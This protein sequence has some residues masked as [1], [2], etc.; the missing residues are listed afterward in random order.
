M[1]VAGIE[2]HREDE[3]RGAD[4]AHARLAEAL[5]LG[6]IRRFG[7]FEDLARELFVIEVRVPG[8]VGMDLGAVD[9]DHAGLDQAAARAQREHLAEQSGQRILMAFDEPRD[10]RVIRPLLRRQHP[11]R[12]VFLTCALDHARRPDPSRI[13]V[14]QKPTI[15]A[16]S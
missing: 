3:R 1:I 14:K 11:E 4:G 13:R 9:G 2:Y 6:G 12:D 10:R 16:G 7:L 15:I 8:R 5:V